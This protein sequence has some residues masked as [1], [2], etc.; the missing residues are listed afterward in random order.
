MV[1]RYAGSPDLPQAVEAA[2]RAQ[3]SSDAAVQYG[4]AAARI[5]ERV[6]LGQSVEEVRAWGG[7]RVA[8]GGR[9]VATPL[10]GLAFR[11]EVAEYD[12]GHRCLLWQWR[13]VVFVWVPRRFMLAGGAIGL[14]TIP[15]QQPTSS[16]PRLMPPL[17][18]GSPQA[19]PIAAPGTPH[20]KP[21]YSPSPRN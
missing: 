8:W 7:R 12:D 21:L 14:W 4:L 20:P 6:V 18:T 15:V 10:Q 11:A 1:A 19:H 13:T 2:V 5:L 9:R 16:R 3:Q 17:V